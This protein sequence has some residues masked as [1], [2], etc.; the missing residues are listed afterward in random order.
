MKHISY[1]IDKKRKELQKLNNTG[2]TLAHNTTT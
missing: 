1:Y 2:K